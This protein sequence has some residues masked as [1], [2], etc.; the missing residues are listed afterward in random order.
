[1]RSEIV[2]GEKTSITFASL[3]KD[4]FKIIIC[5]NAK[6]PSLNHDTNNN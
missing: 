2:Y 5:S 1:M 3:V 4:V 6:K